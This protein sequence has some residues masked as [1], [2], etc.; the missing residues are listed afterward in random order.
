M[1]QA[2]NV[3]K[4]KRSAVAG[5][6]PA[7]TDLALG[8]LALNTYDGRIYLKKSVSNVETVVALQPFPTDGTT[9]QILTLDESG[10]LTWVTS[11]VT[12]SGTVTNASVVNANGF[13]GTVAT[14]TTTPAITIK[15]TV[16]GLLKGNSTT[17]A[18]SAATAGTDYLTPS[19]LSGYA[20]ESYVGTAI[21]G[22]PTTSVRYDISQSLTANQQAQARNNINATSFED[23]YLFSLIF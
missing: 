13:A 11:S 10:N 6:I 8:E 3:V 9:G 21:A 19:N 5:K 15:T 2:A 1:A 20:T 22:I 12:S 14:S 17:G 18:V 23:L 7:T 16:D 4:F